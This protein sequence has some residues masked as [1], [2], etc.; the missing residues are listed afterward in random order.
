MVGLQTEACFALFISLRFSEK[1]QVRNANSTQ[2][3][4]ESQKNKKCETSLWQ[5]IDLFI[6]W[7][8]WLLRTTIETVEGVLSRSLS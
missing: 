4:R 8:V 6:Q 2:R 1:K 3:L 7:E 5:G